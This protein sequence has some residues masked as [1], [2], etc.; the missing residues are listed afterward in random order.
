MVVP[1]PGV[2]RT[3]SCSCTRCTW[4]RSTRPLQH[5]PSFVRALGLPCVKFVFPT[6]PRPK[7]SW[8]QGRED[9]IAAWYN[10]YTRGD[11]RMST[12][13]STRCACSLSAQFRSA[14]GAPRPRARPP[15]V[16][17]APRGPRRPRVVHRRPSPP[18]RPPPTARAPASDAD[19]HERPSGAGPARLADAPPARDPRPRGGA[20][21][22]RL[23]ESALAGASEAA[24]SRSMRCSRTRA[25]SAPSSACARRSS[26]PSRCP[27]TSGTATRRS[28]VFVFTGDEDNVYTP[29][30]QEPVVRAPLRGAAR[31]V[32]HRAQLQPLGVL[33]QRD[34]LR[35]RLDRARLPQGGLRVST[36]V[37]WQ[38]S[39]S[40]EMQY[41]AAPAGCDA[42]QPTATSRDPP[43]RSLECPRA[44]P[45]APA[46][47]TTAVRRV[48]P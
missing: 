15:A 26:T 37:S 11:A 17:G 27:R 8:P 22:R 25:P 35:R 46:V 44:P 38:R 43:S 3:P 36:A 19:W 39:S 40:P 7:I 2:Q 48:R 23:V 33:A 47:G 34:P 24:P 45:P 1:A 13:S 9:N 14:I 42:P 16:L 21:R 28:P 29:Q 10:Y 4:R 41:R 31:R 5:L 18:R 20:P 32:P 6:A 30:L 12:T